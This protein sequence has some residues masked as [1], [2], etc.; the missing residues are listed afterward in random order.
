MKLMS[1]VD[2]ISSIEYTEG[3]IIIKDGEVIAERY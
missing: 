3:I 2:S 1:L